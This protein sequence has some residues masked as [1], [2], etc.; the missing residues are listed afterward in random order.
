MK[1]IVIGIILLACFIGS[2]FMNIAAYNKIVIGVVC[3]FGAVT[4]LK[5]PDNTGDE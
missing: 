3:M 2:L 1:R 4:M 5:T